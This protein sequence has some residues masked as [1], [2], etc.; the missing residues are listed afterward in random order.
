MIDR[1]TFHPNE[2]RRRD[3]LFGL[4]KRLPPASCG[5]TAIA[6]IRDKWSPVDTDAVALRAARV[7]IA[8]IFA[9]PTDTTCGDGAR[10]RLRLRGRLCAVAR[11]H[12]LVGA[13]ESNN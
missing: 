4:K 1:P 9:S 8:T 11:R 7:S 5:S 2:S 10:G 6:N 3:V 12:V 13:D